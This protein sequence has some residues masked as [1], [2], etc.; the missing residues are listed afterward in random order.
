MP[1]RAS[2]D[3]PGAVLLIED[4]ADV[5]RFLHERLTAQGFLVSEAPSGERGLELFDGQRF[6][7]VLLDVHLPGIDGFSVLRSIRRTSEVPVLLLT[8]ASDE[9]DRVLGLEIGADDYVTKPFLPR[10]L[11]ARIRA[12]LRRARPAERTALMTFEHLVI[13]PNARE[14]LVGGEVVKLTGREFDLLAFMASSPRRTFTREQL[15]QQVWNSEASWQ[16]V[17]TVTEH[18]HRL[19]R[20]IEADPAT[21]R[22]LVTVRGA[23]YRFDP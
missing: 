5:R 7:V 14:V 9:A 2:A 6:D 20:R 19:R 3:R 1:D 23:G 22:F 16:N 21:P 15:L 11:V 4:D 12:L 13:D 17:A 8:A 18:V 10:E